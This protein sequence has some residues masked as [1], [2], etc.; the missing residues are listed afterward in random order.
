[1]FG[2]VI[3]ARCVDARRC[4]VLAGLADVA[5]RGPGI[6]LV[7][8]CPAGITGGVDARGGLVLAGTALVARCVDARRGLVLAGLAAGADSRA[9]DIC[10]HVITHN[11]GRSSIECLFTS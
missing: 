2:G 10:T 8:A 4:L 6:C 9:C 1:M 11:K 7:L 5:R 3:T